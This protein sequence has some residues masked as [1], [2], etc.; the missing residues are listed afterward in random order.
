M[1]S[2]FSWVVLLFRGSNSTTTPEGSIP[3]AT[4]ENRK[5]IGRKKTGGFVIFGTPEYLVYLYRNGHH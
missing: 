4:A 2:T 3:G 1:I 5:K